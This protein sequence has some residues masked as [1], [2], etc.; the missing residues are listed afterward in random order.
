VDT[1][2]DRIHTPAD[3]KRLSVDELKA[4]SA[5]IRRY[6][7]E[8]VSAQGGHLASSLGCV[9]IALALHYVFDSPRDKILWDVG[10]QSYTHKIITGRKEKFR[11]IRTRSGI[12]GFPCMSESEHDTF[13][14]GHASTSISAALGLAVARDMH[15]ESNFIISVVGDGALSGGMSFEGINQA[16]HLNT[17]RF[18]IILN[19]NEMSISRNVGALSRYL[20]KITTRKLYLQLEADVWEL[21]GK[22]PSLGGRARKLARRIKE[23]IKNLVVPTI[24]FEELGFR[25]L[26]PLDGHDLEQLVE[27][28]TQI[29]QVPGPILVHVVT[30][31]GKGYTFAEKDAER[32]HGIGSFYKTTGNSRINS[33]KQTYSKIF[34]KTLVE[35][36]EQDEKVV[37]I[38]AAM[39]EGTGLAVFEERFPDRFYDVGIA[40]QH[41]VT[42]AAGLACA[43][44]KPFVAIY[45]TFLQRSFDQIIHD[46]ALQ[47]LPVRLV[48]DRAGVVGEDG[49]T[50][51]G[52]FDLSY[53]RLVPG[54]VLMTPRDEDELRQM[55]L[56]A[57]QYDAGPIAIRFPRGA[58]VGVALSNELKPIEIG[59][60]ELLREGSDVTLVAVGT[61]VETA[62]DA[63]NIL[64]GSGVEANVVNARF[65][66]PLDSELIL[67][68]AQKGH[69]IV[70]I[71]ENAV[72]GGFGDG[73]GEILD[74]H[75]LQ[76][77]VVRI[78][79]PD[80]FI[81]HGKREDLLAEF[82]L[83]SDAVARKV[84]EIIR[85]QQSADLGGDR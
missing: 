31:K 71:E 56:T 19:D 65:I 72:I 17:K 57:L 27:T 32:F 35:L 1:L 25:Y 83:S 85:E 58:V 13:G 18:I 48:L 51:H 52:S 55:L 41:A 11:N 9:E 66:K 10:H 44:M 33:K 60:G 59:R 2:L 69:P 81:P 36:A 78:G 82:G 14:V 45:S 39:K 84:R 30:R 4:L 74:E 46:V 67:S 15:G 5:E 54:I 20:T 50:H 61:M 43:G 22:I 40:E 79:L 75:G 73:I 64:A 62:M 29:K 68:L 6:I 28:F 53:L 34:G 49:P 3:L 70:T 37:A 63:A 26:G 76:N 80:R 16:G 23:S 12:S 47:R 24:L 21:L 77:H 38:T 8:I 7:I 42:F